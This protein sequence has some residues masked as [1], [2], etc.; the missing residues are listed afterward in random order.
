M[1]PELRS[2]IKAIMN[3]LNRDPD[4]LLLISSLNKEKDP[5]LKPELKKGQESNKN[6]C[7]KRKLI[8]LLVKFTNC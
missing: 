7:S 3:T 8:K 2:V 6:L 5:E 4:F 1:D